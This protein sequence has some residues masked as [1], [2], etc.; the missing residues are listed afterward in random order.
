MCSDYYIYITIVSAVSVSSMYYGVIKF[1]LRIK[2]PGI[3]I[4]IYRF[5]FEEVSI[6]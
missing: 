4:S 2:S 5:Q 1:Q 6:I 3:A